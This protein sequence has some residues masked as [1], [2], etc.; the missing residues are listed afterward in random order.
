VIEKLTTEL[1][2]AWRSPPSFMYRHG[3][4]EKAPGIVTHAGTLTGEQGGPDFR[5]VQDTWSISSGAVSWCFVHTDCFDAPGGDVTAQPGPR[6]G[7]TT[8]GITIV[9]F[10]ERCPYAREILEAAGLSMSLAARPE[11]TDRLGSEKSAGR[12]DSGSAFARQHGV[13]L[14][15]RVRGLDVDYGS[16]M[17]ATGTG[18]AP[19]GL[20]VA[21]SACFWPSTPQSTLI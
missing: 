20:A 11:L 16:T 1:C 14:R 21:E 5:A 6:G 2:P 8:I 13:K 17:T 19:P 7:A 3:P 18:P 10:I 9:S 15:S 12:T 4:P